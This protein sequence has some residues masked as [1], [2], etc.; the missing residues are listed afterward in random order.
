MQVPW[1]LPLRLDA[2]LKQV[3]S[4]GRLQLPR[5]LDI[6]VQAAQ[7]VQCRDIF[8]VQCVCIVPQGERVTKTRSMMALDAHIYT[9]P[10]PLSFIYEQVIKRVDTRETLATHHQNSSTVRN[11]NTGLRDCPN[12]EVD[13]FCW[14]L[15][16]HNV[17]ATCVRHKHEHVH[18]AFCC[19]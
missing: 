14:G 2:V 9:A 1:V 17:Q 4:R 10:V 7:I 5:R 6:V 13:C 16:N 3:E 11:V 8:L 18:R 15:S 19:A 12:L